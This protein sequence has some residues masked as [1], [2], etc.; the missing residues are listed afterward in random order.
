MGRFVKKHDM[1]AGLSAVE[2]DG[3]FNG[4]AFSVGGA[5]EMESLDMAGIADEVEQDIHEPYVVR[6][7][8][9]KAN[10]YRERNKLYGDNYKRFGAIMSLML[11]GQNLDCRDHQLMNRLGVLVQVVAKMTRYGENFSRGGHNDSLDDISVYSM[12]LKELDNA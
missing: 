6:E 8:L 7:L 3:E 5:E 9:A 2:T 1:G 4:D 12:M 10:V 11:D